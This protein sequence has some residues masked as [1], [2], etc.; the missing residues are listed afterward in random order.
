MSCL[1]IC[2]VPRKICILTVAWYSKFRYLIN[3]KLC[4]SPQNSKLG[5]YRYPESLPHSLAGPSF[6]CYS[7]FPYIPDRINKIKADEPQEN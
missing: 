1:R 7:S 3:M 2:L 5:C 6:G 4:R